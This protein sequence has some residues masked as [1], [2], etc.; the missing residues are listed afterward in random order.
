MVDNGPE[1]VSNA[2][3]AWAYARGVKLQFIRPGKPVGNCYMESFNGRF[4]DECLNENWFINLDDAREV[5]EAWRVD[6]N[7][8]RPHSSLG[9]LTPAEFKL[10]ELAKSA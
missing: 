4:R 6:Y 8:T 2:V 10:L 7:Q 1:F 3:D 9:D 5:V